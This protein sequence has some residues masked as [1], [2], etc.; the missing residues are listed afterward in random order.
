M[1]C[2]VICCEVPEIIKEIVEENSE[3]Y[4]EQLFS[5]LDG[6]LSLDCFLAGYFEK[7]LEML[8]RLN[9]VL[10]MRFLNSRG[11]MMLRRFLRHID[12]YS[13]MQIVQRLMLPHI[14]FANPS[15]TELTSIEDV[16]EM[17]QCRWS[18]E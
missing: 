1:S 10:L 7:I 5:I 2:E 14:P 11:L 3:S 8:F 15:D 13:I 4:L 17:Y 6:E 9:T 12:N 16:H 18:Y